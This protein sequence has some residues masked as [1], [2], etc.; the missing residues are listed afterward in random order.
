MTH[1]LFRHQLTVLNDFLQQCPTKC[2]HHR[3]DTTFWSFSISL[4]VTDAD[5]LMDS[6]GSQAD[7]SPLST[8]A[9]IT[10]P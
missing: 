1:L 4:K 2:S 7:M 9:T 3:T 6:T 10:L 5:I 8:I